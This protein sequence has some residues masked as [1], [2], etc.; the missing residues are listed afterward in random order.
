MKQ[1][2]FASE[3][4]LSDFPTILGAP[5]ENA[6][7]AR[8][9]AAKGA[10]FRVQ[11]SLMNLLV[12]AVHSFY[13]AKRACP[14]LDAFATGQ[15]GLLAMSVRK[16]SDS[17]LKSAVIGVGTTID[18]TSGRTRSL[19][20]ALNA[21]ETDLNNRK[22]QQ[23]DDEI[24]AALDLLTYIRRQ[25]NAN[26]VGSL[27]YV[28]HLRNKWAGH[29]SLDRMVD[30]WAGADKSVD[31]RIVEDALARMV[32]AF[33]DLSVLVPMSKDLMDIEAQANSP[34]ERPDGTVVVEMKVAW[35]GANALA[36]AMRYSAQQAADAFIWRLREESGSRGA[37]TATAGQS[38][39]TSSG[40]RTPPSGM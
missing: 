11:E 21:L 7:L 34:Q 20:D 5:M 35:S 4:E 16:V 17:L 10:A 6:S 28:R 1:S 24:D 32:N 19:P 3:F 39:P 9:L 33:Q 27:K 12:D 22:A 2:D 8:Q 29:S 26:E 14:A 38:A 23:P 13:F 37:S 36:E 15:A 40:G 31:F 18:V 30:G 25:T